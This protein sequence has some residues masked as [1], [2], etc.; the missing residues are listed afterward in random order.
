[1]LQPR[2]LPGFNASIDYYDIKIEDAI[3]TAAGAQEII[4]RCYIQNETQFCQYIE[5]VNGMIRFVYITPTNFVETIN[6]GIDIEA[7]YTRQ[8]LGGR[9][10]IRWLAPRHLE[11]LNHN[12]STE[13]LDVVGQHGTNPTW[14]HRFTVAYSRDPF[15]IDLTARAISSGTID[16]SW[17]EC[18]SGCPTSTVDHR[19]IQV[20]GNHV[21]GYLLF[22]A[23][24]NYQFKL[25]GGDNEFFVNVKNLADKDPPRIASNST[26]GTRGNRGTLDGTYDLLGR[27]YRAGVRFKF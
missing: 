9:T 21:P 3:G 22:D 2:F 15:S 11:S 5:R 25:G 1:M 10:T 8:L 17:I 13:P 19:T 18:N 7:A 26:Q 24:F 27:V 6:R 16:N 14:R 23:G 4:D 20:G 12:G